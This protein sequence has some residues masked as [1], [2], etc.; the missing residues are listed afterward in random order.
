M[1]SYRQQLSDPR[2]QKKRLEILNRDGFACALCDDKK[3]TLHVHH[4]YY[5][6]GKLAWDYEPETL[7]TLC[8][9]CHKT[10]GIEMAEVHRLIAMFHPYHLPLIK[11]VLASIKTASDLDTD[12]MPESL[13]RDKQYYIDMRETLRRTISENVRC[14]S[15]MELIDALD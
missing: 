4:G 6:A 1:P 2:W 14:M 3:S 12:R 10:V 5:E 8:E 7:I 9:N 13:E 15:G 11:G